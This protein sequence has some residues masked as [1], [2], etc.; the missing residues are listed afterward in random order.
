MSY[1]PTPESRQ[2]PFSA[3]HPSPTL[4]TTSQGPGSTLA[5]SK[6]PPDV[7]KGRWGAEEA[8][9]L[10]RVGDVFF[11]NGAHKDDW[12]GFATQLRG[13]ARFRSKPAIKAK[14]GQLVKERAKQVELDKAKDEEETED[15]KVEPRSPTTRRMTKSMSPGP[16][17]STAFVRHASPT[18][19]A[20]GSFPSTSASFLSIRPASPVVQPVPPPPPPPKWTL[21]E[22]AALL[23]T[24]ALRPMIATTWEVLSATAAR[25]YSGVAGKP[26]TKTTTQVQERWEKGWRDTQILTGWPASVAPFFV[27][28]SNR[29][30]FATQELVSELSAAPQTAVAPA[31]PLPRPNASVSATLAASP[32]S[33]RPSQVA[34]PL[35][36]GPQPPAPSTSPSRSLLV[37]RKPE[38]SDQPTLVLS[39]PASRRPSLASSGGGERYVDIPVTSSPYGLHSNVPASA[40][41]PPSAAVGW[42]PTVPRSEGEH[43]LPSS[44]YPSPSTT[45]SDGSP[46][47]THQPRPPAQ[48]DAPRQPSFGFFSTA[49]LAAVS[50]TLAPAPESKPV[51]PLQDSSS[52]TTPSP[53]KRY[54]GEFTAGFAANISKTPSFGSFS[55]GGGLGATAG[56]SG[57][58]GLGIS[59]SGGA[60]YPPP[61]ASLDGL[62]DWAMADPKAF[63]PP[64]SGAKTDWPSSSSD[65]TAPLDDIKVIDFGG[66]GAPNEDAVAG[67]TSAAQ[68]LFPFLAPAPA[69][70]DPFS[71]APPTQRTAAQP[72][73]AHKTPVRPQRVLR[74]SFA[75]EIDVPASPSGSGAGARRTSTRKRTKEVNYVEREPSSESQSSSTSSSALPSSPAEA[76]GAG[77]GADSGAEKKEP[78]KSKRA[79]ERKKAEGLSKRKAEAEER[80]EWRASGS[81]E[82]DEVAVAMPKKKARR[83]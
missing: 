44:H 6:D 4:S 55:T 25:T 71:A 27:T 2:S 66:Y 60:P 56:T 40:A 17:R 35:V 74:A 7:R 50:A 76:S 22:D 19:F 67:P 9:E 82:D 54:A 65:A 57:G 21:D 69:P 32:P 77:G 58:I 81:D 64:H 38:P 83:A 11:A 34:H 16:S 18:P 52:Y 51:I 53:Q 37:V 70:A 73:T 61:Y 49:P 12:A 28:Q 80:D 36:A 46:A 30:A 39:G 47:Q 15:I 8:A 75:V 43:K 48:P 59:T 31:P 45:A 68:S 42:T 41:P 13:D 63:D 10:L 3:H 5:K 33:Q 20:T 14:Y 78:R 23:S 62:P 79:P 24:I 72:G 29:L 26:W 1:L